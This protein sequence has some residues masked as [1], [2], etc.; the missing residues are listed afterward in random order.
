MSATRTSSPTSSPGFRNLTHPRTSSVR[1]K[2]KTPVPATSIPFPSHWRP[3]QTDPEKRVQVT[4]E[5]A[6]NAGAETFH[7]FEFTELGETATREGNIFA[8]DISAEQVG[9]DPRNNRTVVTAHNFGE[10]LVRHRT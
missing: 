1:R 8:L 10:F 9:V 3:A 5:G 4:L 7:P 2:S 6:E